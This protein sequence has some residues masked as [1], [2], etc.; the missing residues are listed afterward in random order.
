MSGS[1]TG[2]AGVPGV[3]KGFRA[4][5]SIPESHRR[6]MLSAAGDVRR[7]EGA[8]TGGGQ[9]WAV[10]RNPLSYCQL[11]LSPAAIKPIKETI[12]RPAV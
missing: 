2:Q 4:V 3:A 7:N 10:S 11:L 8:S 5:N 9:V 12:S 1:S 6:T